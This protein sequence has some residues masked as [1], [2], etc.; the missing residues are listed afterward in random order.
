MVSNAE[1]D[2]F[3]MG[4]KE[5]HAALASIRSMPLGAQA[6]RWEEHARWLAGVVQRHHDKVH[7]RS[8]LHCMQ[9]N[10]VRAWRRGRDARRAELMGAVAS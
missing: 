4:P 7:A 8:L 1:R 6:R 9:T 5:W 3:A 10:A 2:P